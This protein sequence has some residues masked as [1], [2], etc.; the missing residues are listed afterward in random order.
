[1]QDKELREICLFIIIKFGSK[2]NLAK[3]KKYLD[4]DKESAEFFRIFWRKLEN[5]DMQFYY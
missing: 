1:L 3:L 5:R 2:E 4:T